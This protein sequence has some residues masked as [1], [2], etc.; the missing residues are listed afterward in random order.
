MTL[1]VLRRVF[2]NMIVLYICG[3]IHLQGIDVGDASQDCERDRGGHGWYYGAYL[4]S[5]RFWKLSELGKH[6]QSRFGRPDHP[7]GQ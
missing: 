7:D 3:R 5:C 6:T 1:T 4:R 2:P